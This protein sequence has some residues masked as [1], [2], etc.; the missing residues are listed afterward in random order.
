MHR[1][2]LVEPIDNSE[3]LGL[4]CGRRPTNRLAGHAE[5]ARGRLLGAH[6]HRAGWIV[7]DEHDAQTRYDAGRLQPLY[8]GADFGEH[9]PGDGGAVDDIAAHR[10]DQLL[11]HLT[12]GAGCTRGDDV[13]AQSRRPSFPE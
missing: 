12:N 9:T 6:I 7:A 4:R 3:K 2:V 8:L 5:L 1:P 10:R 11:C 13:T